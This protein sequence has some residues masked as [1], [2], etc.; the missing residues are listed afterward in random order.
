LG[1][2][3]GAKDVLMTQAMLVGHWHSIWLNTNHGD[4]TSNNLEALATP[5]Q[6]GGRMR[7]RGSTGQAV[8][9]NQWGNGAQN[10]V[11]GS[12]RT[13]PTQAIPTMSPYMLV[14]YEVVAG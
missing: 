11:S 4:G 13:N 14:N 6:A 10:E 9:G 12:I 2:V 3:G 1:A 5:L 7:Y 8:N